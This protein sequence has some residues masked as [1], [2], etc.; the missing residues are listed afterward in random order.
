MNKITK[1][2][3]GLAL[4][5]GILTASAQLTPYNAIPLI[6]TATC[7]EGNA[8]YTNGVFDVPVG[9]NF[10]IFITLGG[11]NASG[12]NFVVRFVPCDASTNE[13][14]DKVWTWTFVNAGTARKTAFTNVLNIWENVPKMRVYFTNA[15]NAGTWVSNCT[16]Y[17]R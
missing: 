5:L 9:Q 4:L 17:R 8:A 11:T 12:S 16:V 2:F 6:S 13:V 15:H 14:N 3:A 1:F 10:S 7:L